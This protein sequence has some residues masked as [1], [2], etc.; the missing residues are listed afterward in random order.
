M[1]FTTI[2][3]TLVL[4][5]VWHT[6]PGVPKSC[7]VTS[8]AM[9]Y[10]SSSSMCA[11]KRYGFRAIS[12]WNLV[13]ILNSWCEIGFTKQ[14]TH[15]HQTFWGVPNLPL[16]DSTIAGQARYLKLVLESCLYNKEVNILFLW[17]TMPVHRLFTEGRLRI[18]EATCNNYHLS[19]KWC[20][21]KLYFPTYKAELFETLIKTLD[22]NSRFCNFTCWEFLC[23]T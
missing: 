17:H 21:W 6:N 14:A 5:L 10:K 3:Q 20:K 22:V 2:P 4:L 15:P 18:N 8:S 12:V 7:C 16:L 11:L 1:C 9:L 19:C 13:Y 23:Y